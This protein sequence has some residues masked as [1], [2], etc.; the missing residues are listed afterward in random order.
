VGIIFIGRQQNGRSR[1]GF[2]YSEIIYKNIRAIFEFY[3][4]IKFKEKIMSKSTAI[5]DILKTNQSIALLA[6]SSADHCVTAYELLSPLGIVLEIAFRT[7]AAMQGIIE[8]LRKHPDALILAGTVMTPKQAQKAIDAGVAGIVSADY[9]PAVVELCVKNDIMCVPGGLAD[10]GKQLVQKAQLYQCEFDELSKK[11]PYQWI[12]KLFPA[13]AGDI[14]HLGLAKAW[15]GPFKDL[16]MVYTGG[17]NLENLGE[18]VKTDPNG[19]FCGSALAKSIDNLDEL[20]SNAKKWK[21]TIQK[22]K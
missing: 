11:Y 7:D 18:L 4:L 10:A 9:I 14:N 5:F 15:K 12:Y 17:I 21:A 22:F 6:P 19:I 20:V 2:S 1:S 3:I 8:T 16:T 13:I